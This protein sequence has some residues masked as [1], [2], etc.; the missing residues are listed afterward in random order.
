[1]PYKSLSLTVFTQRDFVEDFIQAKCN[2]TPKT[3]VLRFRGLLDG[4]HRGN[5]WWSS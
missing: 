4:G 2:F 5:V 3:S 1:M